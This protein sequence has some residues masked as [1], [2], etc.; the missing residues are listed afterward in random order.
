MTALKAA[1]VDRFLVSP[2]A[3]RPV[4]LVF[5]P[6]TGLVRERAE[7]I[8]QA[9][10]ENTA[11][12]FSLVRL[13]G[14]DLAADPARLVDEANTIPLFGG[15]RAIWIKSGGRNFV[16]AVEALIESKADCRVVIEAGDL[17]RN[18]PLRSLCERAKSAAAIACYSDSE[19]DV[20]R[21]VDD[22]MRAAGLKIDP[23]ARSALVALLGGDRLASRSEIRKLALYAQGKS[24]VTLDDVAAVVSEASALATD[25]IVDAMFAG[26][27][28]EAESQFSRARAAGTAPGTI[29]SA[30]LRQLLQ[31]HR[32]RLTVEAGRSAAQVVESVQPPLHFRR[33]PLI[34]AALR[35]WTADRLLQAMQ[36]LAETALE[37]RRQPNLADAFALR[38]V[39]SLAT[40]AR[41]RSAQSAGIA[42]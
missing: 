33:K 38:A 2:D 1:E 41:R 4:V 23:D 18:A 20:A 11:D 22:E 36:Q 8:I 42:D 3:A 21:L 37:I 6:D 40:A 27:T 17:R 14:D 7:K 32:M 31:L 12:P 24:E 34:E 26:R 10:V 30:A 16:P 29:A 15:R 9:S 19:R 28:G 39:L 35:A 5:G 25:G 13:E